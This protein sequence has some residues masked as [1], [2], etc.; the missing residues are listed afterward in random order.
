MNFGEIDE[1]LRK[2]E[3]TIRSRKYNRKCLSFEETLLQF[4]ASCPHS[5]TLTNA[6]PGDIRRFLVWKDSFGKSTVHSVD[7]PFI[8]EHG[9]QNCNCPLRL[10]AGTVEGMMQ[11]LK[12]IFES[13]GRIGE[14]NNCTKQGNPV[15]S[16]SLKQYL[17]FV[18]EEQAQAH[19]SPKQ[20]KPIFLTKL[21]TIASYI[22]RQ[23]QRTDL[24]ILERF[25]L[26]RDQA[27]LK[28]Q[29]FAGDRASDVGQVLVQEIRVLSDYTGLLF[30]HTFG[31]TLRG[32]G[33]FNRFVV[34]RC[35]VRDICPVRGL[36]EYF[37][38][39]KLHGID[40][41]S[42]YLFRPVLGG[43]TVL[44]DSMSYSAIYERLKTYLSVL[45]IDEGET[46]H[47][48]RAGCAVTLA[49]SGSV[50]TKDVMNHIG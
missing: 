25:V 20:A 32:D 14:W 26:V 13:V 22:D 49:L 10:S 36:E 46:P 19:V 39:A 34:K 41:S 1:R 21:K 43:K 9:T 15:M 16:P 11:Q 27:L 17:K 8:G 28:L 47:S 7:C 35:D 6:L 40:L 23:L 44:N 45:G 18:K 3:Q 38:V 2:M 50:E 37:R 48:M 42:G 24:T 5:P 31:K 33:K 29:F 4:F 12:K 30:N